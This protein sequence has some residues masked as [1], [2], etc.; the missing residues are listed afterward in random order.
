MVIYWF[1]FVDELAQPGDPF[2]LMDHFPT[3]LQPLRPAEPVRLYEASEWPDLPALLPPAAAA[4][5]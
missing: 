5:P 2:V 4:P 1:G 3:D